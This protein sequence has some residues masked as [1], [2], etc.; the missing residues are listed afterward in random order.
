MSPQAEGQLQ[1][2]RILLEFAQRKKGNLAETFR[3][4]TEYAASGVDVARASVWVLTGGRNAGPSGCQADVLEC[5]DLYLRDE[6]R[7]VR[8]DRLRS[9]DFPRYFEALRVERTIAVHDARNDPRTAEFRVG[10]LDRLG[11]TS[12]LD[13][14]VWSRGRIWGILC[15]E[16]VGPQRRWRPEEVDFATLLSD[17]VAFE[18][19]APGGLK[20]EQWWRT[21]AGVLAE[22]VVLV[23]DKGL[24]LWMNPTARATFDRLT[25]ARTREETHQVLEFRDMSGN[26]I[27]PGNW[28]DQR[29][30]RGETIS[31][32]LFEVRV[33]P[34]GERRIYRGT[35]TPVGEPGGRRGVVMVF[36]DV[37][38]EVHFERLKNDFLTALAHELKTPLAI[39]KTH[40][41]MVARQEELPPRTRMKLDAILRATS[42]MERLT[43]DLM[44]VSSIMAG[45][46][47]LVRERVDVSSLARRA[48]ER[49]DR[50]EQEQRLQLSA[51]APVFVSAD[52]VRLEHVLRQLVDNALRYSTGGP[53]QVDVREDGADALLSVRDEGIGIPVEKQKHLF[54][55]FFRAHAGT[56]FD[57]GGGVGL[58][59]FI[60]RKIVQEHGG[61]LSFESREGHGSVFHVRLPLAA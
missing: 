9:R 61:S 26:L 38:A 14:S 22:G 29:V 3:V 27:P 28:P 25:R 30:L 39:A 40:A 46:L 54:E 11:I 16:H 44:D 13:V 57:V 32:E 2:Q 42:R 56:P 17:V 23:D 31:A 51:P 20:F 12:M 58:G 41:Q 45:R 52:R 24:V 21:V 59:L 6:G 48:V 4:V 36:T 7:H 5:E 10:Y 53:V 43:D 8:G 60:A 47:D 33:L 50:G 37:T 55:P 15:L 49:T 35:A 19:E 34:A 18:L 1:Q